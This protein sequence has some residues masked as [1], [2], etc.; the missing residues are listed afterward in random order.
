MGHGVRFTVR[1]SGMIHGSLKGFFVGKRGLHQVGPLSPFLFVIEMEYLSRKLKML[2]TL[3]GFSYHPKCHRLALTYLCFVDDLIVFCR[4]NTTSMKCV[5]ACLDDSGRVSGLRVNTDKRD[6]YCGG[7]GYLEKQEIV[8]I[9][10]M[11]EGNM[12]M[13]Y[14]VDPLHQK[15]LS[16]HDYRPFTYSIQRMVNNWA[17][18]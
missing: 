1:F 17:T 4:G 10:G 2:E 9:T 18:R 13:R 16:F 6:I 12:P 15:N 11:S 3:N 5:K 7:L 14:L 8:A